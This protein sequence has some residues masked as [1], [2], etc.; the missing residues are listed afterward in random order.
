MS[1]DHIEYLKR[2]I[3]RIYKW[4]TKEQLDGKTTITDVANLFNIPVDREREAD[5]EVKSIDYNNL[6]IEI[7][8]KKNN[9]RYIG[10]YTGDIDLLNYGGPKEFIHVKAINP[11]YLKDSTYY[12][13]NKKAVIEQI[14]FTKGDYELAF[15]KEYPNFISMNSCEAEKNEVTYSKNLMY[16]NKIVNQ[17]LL[18]KIYEDNFTNVDGTFEQIFTYL[19]NSYILRKNEQDKYTYVRHNSVIYGINELELDRQYNLHGI[20]FENT[21]IKY[22]ERY[23][24]LNLQEERFPN[25]KD[26]NVVS[27][28]IL[29][30]ITQNDLSNTL[31]IYK[32]DNKIYISYLGRKYLDCDPFYLD[33]INDTL[34]LPILNAD[35]ITSE[36]IECIIST[37][38]EKYPENI[39]VEV[40]INEL[41]VFASKINIRKKIEEEVQD[42]ALSPKLF[43][44]KSF[45][46][47]GNMVAMD[48]DAYFDLANQ[49]F[50]EAIQ[51]VPKNEE[52][53]VQVLK[54]DIKN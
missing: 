12:I 37:L 39:F 41:H 31:E 4:Y 27:A 20:C 14:C 24:P 33:V 11:L 47:I 6:S 22:L 3:E 30:G 7:I 42:D 26:K 40:V 15:L 49:Q 17:R 16:N 53:H 45:D 50:L 19:I 23:F 51:E 32:R 44:K 13:E 21:H 1:Q 2:K 9:T 34:E 52:T 35:T 5:Y 10:E 38:K 46:E 36:E 28:M 54:R 29:Q 8:D 43:A 18:T 25:V 48:K